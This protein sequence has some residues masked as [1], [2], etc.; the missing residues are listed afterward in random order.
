MGTPLEGLT[1][2]EIAGIGPGPHA[3][4][5]LADLGADVVRIVR[6]GGETAAND[7]T[8]RGR[9]SRIVDMKTLEGV[10][11]VLRLVRDA[12]VLIEGFRPGVTERLGI[13]PD[14][15]LAINPSLIYVRM[16]GWG[17]NGPFAHL[18]GHDI[19]YLSITGVLAAIGTPDTPVPPLNV[20]GDNGGGSLFALVGILAAIWRRERT[21]VGSVVDAAI[22]DGVAVLAQQILE[23]EAGGQWSDGQRGRN[24]L[25]GGA[26][27]YRTYQCRDGNFVAVGAI[28]PQFYVLLV[29]GLGL[30]P[31]QLPDRGENENWPELTTA[32]A[33]RFAE[34]D[35]DHW[36]FV[37][38]GTDA[39]VTP[40]LTF[41]EA[42]EHEQIRARQSLMR[43]NDSTTAG[44]APVIS[45]GVP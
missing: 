9:S 2:V 16:T 42:V 21:G 14:D 38:D 3:S 39:C 18:A 28:E 5:I 26:P 8:T 25:D 35:R 29:R 40:V 17:Q 37:F 1:V 15:C 24:L 43:F 23:L 11:E 41:A 19:N 27:Y 6:P 4:M 12:D 34:Y 20:V 13:G 22:I 44:V 30:D 10:S 45:D 7:H 31:V 33:S 32:F 36:L